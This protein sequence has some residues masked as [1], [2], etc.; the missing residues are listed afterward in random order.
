[1]LTEKISA[2]GRI[3]GAYTLSAVAGL[4]YGKTLREKWIEG[5]YRRIYHYHVRKTG[6]T[7]INH[8][9]LST[10]GETGQQVYHRLLK[11]SWAMTRSGDK[12]FVGWDRH[13][14]EPGNYHFA[15]SHFPF[16]E[17]NLPADTLTI[18]C[19][20]DP[21]ERVISHYR[22]LATY[23]EDRQRGASN[24]SIDEEMWLLGNGFPA[25]LERLPREMLLTQL[26]M[27][28]RQYDPDEAAENI[29][30]CNQVLHTETLAVGMGELGKSLGIDIPVLTA[31][32]STA[33]PPITEEDR[34]RLRGLLEPEY[35]FLE[36]IDK[37]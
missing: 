10:G 14:I 24:S 2:I 15:F 9:L 7:S 6:G 33:T 28:S 23:I 36:K 12:I 5:R 4:R 34:D 1:M 31:R 8:G 11:N 18:T 25:Y 13:L 27:F 32:K 26:Y 17:L 29:A 20:R 37:P 30:K 16:Y 35:R 22:M 19:L 21:V 3:G